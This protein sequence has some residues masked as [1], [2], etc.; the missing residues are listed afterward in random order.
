MQ[1]DYMVSCVR[2][3]LGFCYKCGDWE[4]EFIGM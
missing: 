4:R 2:R 1:P 3:N